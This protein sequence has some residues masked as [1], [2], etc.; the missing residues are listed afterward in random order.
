MSAEVSVLPVALADG[1]MRAVVENISPSVDGGRFPI[2]RVVGDV[3][4]V[5]ADCFADGHD[6]V[7]CALM[8]RRPGETNWRNAP[9]AP[10]GNDRWRAGFRVD[11][12]GAWQYT[13]CAWVDPFL[14]WRH[15]FARRVDAQDVRGAARTGAMLLEEAASRASQAG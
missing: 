15:D 9:M 6:V 10:L 1:R 2:K 13:V 11:V 7:A 12:V 14:S 4:E 8:W 3:V 5:S